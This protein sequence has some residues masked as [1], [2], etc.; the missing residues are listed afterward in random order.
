MEHH[1][2]FNENKKEIRKRIG[3]LETNITNDSYTNKRDCYAYILNFNDIVKELNTIYGSLNILDMV[4]VKAYNIY[5]NY[6][7]T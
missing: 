6:I 7:R 5:H 1:I 3:I 2:V 4:K